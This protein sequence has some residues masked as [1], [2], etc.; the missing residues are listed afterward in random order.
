MRYTVFL[1]VWEGE[2]L[3]SLKKKN[4]RKPLS[5]LNFNNSDV[6]CHQTF[7]GLLKFI[8]ICLFQR[9]TLTRHANKVILIVLKRVPWSFFVIF[10]YSCLY[11]NM[12]WLTL[13]CS[14]CRCRLCFS[15]LSCCCLIF[16][17]SWSMRLF[18]AANNLWK[19][20]K[21][22]TLAS[23]HFLEVL[24]VFVTCF[25]KSFCFSLINSWSN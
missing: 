11:F 6:F 8:R 15:S 23:Q 2:L 17:T 9:L 16:S 14:T 22:Q 19:R 18:W 13:L 10:V 21:S 3:N 24:H 7:V 4:P 20:T 1:F 5:Q 25:Q 12:L